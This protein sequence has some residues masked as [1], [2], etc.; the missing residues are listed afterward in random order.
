MELSI[1]FDGGYEAYEATEILDALRARDIK[2]T[3]F[4]TGLFIKRHQDL[5]R[6]IVLDGHEVGNHMMTH[7]HLTS[8]AKDFTHRRLPGVNRSFLLREL[9]QT[10][11]V[12][13]EVTGAEMAPLWRAPYGEI[14]DTLRRW[15]FQEGYLHVGWTYD[16]GSR[17]SLDT[18]DWVHD[19]SSRFYHSST[20]IK[21]RILG[22]GKGSDGVRGGIILM[23][24][25]T[26][27]RTDRVSSIL[28]EML[29]DLTGMGY[30]FVKVSR[31]LKG[32]KALDTAGGLKKRALGHKRLS[33]KNVDTGP[34]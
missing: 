21:A 28:G 2:T 9:R 1:T 30:R 5:T 33:S 12:F 25:G 4:L 8:F 15:A 6:Q 19:T 16:H 31:L 29:D 32:H 18:L 7:P 26:G 23:H 20:E 17:E 34:S 24:L 14:N 22:F 10:E 27:R 13:K 11:E 3:V